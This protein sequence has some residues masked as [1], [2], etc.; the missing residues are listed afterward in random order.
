MGDLY[1]TDPILRLVDPEDAPYS[2]LVMSEGEQAA[3]GFC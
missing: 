2:F 1:E 3:R